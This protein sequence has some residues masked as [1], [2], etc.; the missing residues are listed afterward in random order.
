[1]RVNRQ[2]R[3]LCWDVKTHLCVQISLVRN[4]YESMMTCIGMLC[5]YRAR[6]FIV[7]YSEVCSLGIHSWTQ[8]FDLPC[9]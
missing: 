4:D 2:V 3:I 5:F 9:G 1:M 8:M 6:L 7:G